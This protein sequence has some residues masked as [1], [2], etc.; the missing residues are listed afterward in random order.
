LSS[1]LTRL[2]NK[3]IRWTGKAALSSPGIHWARPLPIGRYV[4]IAETGMAA[5]QLADLWAG[6]I[7]DVGR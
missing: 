4:F 5:A 3:V 2:E 7:L 1:G 6:I